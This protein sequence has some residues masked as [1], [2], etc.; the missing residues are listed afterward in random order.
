MPKI[1]D[2][3]EKKTAIARASKDLFIEKGFSN[4]TVSEVAKVAGVGK[5]T[6]YEYYES[7]EEIVYEIMLDTQK[8]HDDAIKKKIAKATTPREKVL[9]LFELFVSNDKE[10]VKRRKIYKEFLSI[11]INK[12]E[13]EM[14]CFDIDSH[15]KYIRLLTKILEDGVKKSLLVENA[16]KLA[17]GLYLMA[18]G[19]LVTSNLENKSDDEMALVSHINSLF[20]ILEKE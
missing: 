16:P 2:K 15:E 4:L 10:I 6:I 20:D 3:K 1:V 13:E 17:S 12:T 7:K 5:G 19:F 9:A 14:N 18:D 11:C 8:E